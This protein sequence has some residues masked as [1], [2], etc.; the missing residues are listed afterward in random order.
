MC[1]LVSFEFWRS[2]KRLRGK[3]RHS[4]PIINSL[5]NDS[6]ISKCFADS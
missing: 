5:T 6:D 2:V 1:G 4:S 3:G